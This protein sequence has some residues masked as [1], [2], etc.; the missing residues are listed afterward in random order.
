MD[1]FDIFEHINTNED[2]QFLRSSGN[3][4]AL[5]P[6]P[7][8]PNTVYSLS[9]LCSAFSS[10]ASL[11][12]PPMGMAPNSDAFGLRSTILPAAPLSAP[13]V[14]ISTN[15]DDFGLRS[16]IVP[17]APLSA[18]PMGISSNIDNT[19]ATRE[20][21]HQYFF[22]HDFTTE[23]FSSN[24]G[25]TRIRKPQPLNFSLKVFLGG[26][27]ANMTT[28]VLELNFAR[29]GKSIIDW[30]KKTAQQD[31]PPNGYAFVVFEEEESVFRMLRLSFV[32]NGRLFFYVYM[33]GPEQT[34]HPV[35]VKVW[36]MKDTTHVGIVGWR[37]FRRYSVFV[38]GIPRTCTA[39][40]LAYGI[41]EAIGP[42]AYCA[43]ELDRLHYYPK[44]A[45]CVVFDSKE[46]YVRAIA[47]HDV[48][49]S[50]G[51]FERKVEFKPFLA[52]NMPC[53]KCGCTSGTRFCAEMICLAY[54]CNNC[55]KY[56]HS[57][58]P[59]LNGHIPS[60]RFMRGSSSSSGGKSEQMERK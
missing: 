23:S 29:F 46:T 9:D 30:P 50:F 34:Q 41:Q 28:N 53:E 16:T 12:A 20:R 27:P 35:E 5:A 40:M 10:A 33:L 49:L 2:V 31:R 60:K 51:T 38:G 44:G 48:V 55:W 11:S 54:Y 14:G 15:S 6:Q 45:A 39:A 8:V 57:S 47:A 24:S 3:A 21:N 7:L 42:V 17:S 4:G 26:I 1:L 25:T 43:I 13:P 59:S 58:R 56:A 32:S 37:K 52:S 19:G 18:P 22:G 36:E